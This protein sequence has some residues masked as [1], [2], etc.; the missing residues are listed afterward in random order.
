MGAQRLRLPALLLVMLACIVLLPNIVTSFTQESPTFKTLK[1]DDSLYLVQGKKFLQGEGRRWYHKEKRHGTSWAESPFLS[2][3]NLIVDF[4]FGLFLSTTNLSYH[5]G[6]LVVDF[7]CFIASFAICV[8]IFSLYSNSLSLSVL[9]SFTCLLFPG[10]FLLDWGPT[11]QVFLNK[12]VLTTFVAE[13]KPVFRALYTQVSFVA[14]L[15]LFYHFLKA[16]NSKNFQEQRHWFWHGFLAGGLLFLYFFAWATYL[17]LVPLLFVFRVGRQLNFSVTRSLL[18][19]L[20]GA[21]LSSLIPMYWLLLNGEQG[22]L[23]SPALREYF[24]FSTESLS[25]SVLL[26]ILLKIWGNEP[27]KRDILIILICTQILSILLLNTQPILGKGIAPYHFDQF[28]LFPLFAGFSCLFIGK[29]V[30]DNFS[31]RK[32]SF[33]V[34]SI[35]CVLVF[36]L[37]FMNVQ[38][39]LKNTWNRTHRS[40]SELVEYTRNHT[41]PNAVVAFMSFLS[42]FPASIPL[43][44][45]INNAPLIFSALTDR[46]ILHQDWD[47]YPIEDNDDIKRELLLGAFFRGEP[48]LTWPCPKD[49]SYLP[50]DIFSLTWSYYLLRRE[51]K[52]QFHRDIIRTSS[53][54]SL[55]QSYD[56]DYIILEKDQGLQIHG[57]LSDFASVVF[58]DSNHQYSMVKFEKDKFLSRQCAN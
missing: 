5:T 56:I 7:L 27:A 37:C 46:Y 32:V 22:I 30:F 51:Q 31:T 47:F 11:V 12:I 23:A 42:P 1:I 29:V 57:S 13:G 3:P 14:F 19:F 24:Y 36:A 45:S 41:P 25:I 54:C 6:G 26:T 39:A 38:L 43:N 33:V 35:V 28:Y 4:F 40:Q 16:V 49:R 44:F 52:C 55:L 8:K 34:N 18:M 48:S 2:R 20:V 53:F 9:S 15:T 58:E 17:A 10:F 50:G 21:L